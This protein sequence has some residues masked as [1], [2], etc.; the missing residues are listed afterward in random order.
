M[1]GGLWLGVDAGGT[2]A[3]SGLWLGV[4]AGGTLARSGCWG[5]SG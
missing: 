3:R 5:D 2:L 4:D 1:L